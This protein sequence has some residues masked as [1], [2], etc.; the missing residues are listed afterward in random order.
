MSYYPKTDSH[1][2]N[3]IKVDLSSYTTKSDAENAA[4]VDTSKL[5]KKV[6]L[7]SLKSG[8]HKLDIDQLKTVPDKIKKILI[9][10][11]KFSNVVV[12]D[13]VKKDVYD[14]L[15]TE[16][17]DIDNRKLVTK[18][19]YKTIIKEIENKIPK[20]DK[21][22]TTADLSKSTKENFGGRLKLENL[23]TKTNIADCR[24]LINFNNKNF[25]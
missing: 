24:T 5:A 2:G 25:K 23:A 9:D 4:G 22:I 14:R 18:T 1:I 7:A 20:H 21:F 15:V 10:L 8:I 12:N 13:A 11:K 16:V 3:K 17:N 19:D 6:D